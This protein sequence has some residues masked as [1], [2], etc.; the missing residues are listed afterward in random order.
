M[1]DEKKRE[2]LDAELA[3]LIAQAGDSFEE[4]GYYLQGAYHVVCQRMKCLAPDELKEGRFKEAHR[5]LLEY[6]SLIYKKREHLKTLLEGLV[7]EDSGVGK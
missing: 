7:N 1:S 6:G 2:A 5:S 4:A 3:T